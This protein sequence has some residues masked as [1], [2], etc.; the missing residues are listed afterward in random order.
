MAVG[1]ERKAGEAAMPPGLESFA[2]RFSA[3]FLEAIAFTLRAE[4]G[5]S[6]HPADAGGRTNFGI[7]RNFHPQAWADG[8]VDLA[9]ALAIYHA[10]YW[11]PARGDEL[12]PVLA[13][14]LFDSAVLCGVRRPVQWLQTAVNQVWA[15]AWLL[16]EPGTAG[17]GVS[18]TKLAVDG[19]LGPRTLQ[20]LGTLAVLRSEAPLYLAHCVTWQRQLHHAKQVGHKPDQAVFILGWSHRCADLAQRLW[21]IN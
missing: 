17:Q 18:H 11:R 4:G 19:C 12:P 1:D 21:L 3:A 13:L 5:L 10:E 9:E 7:A 20:A 8:R 6:D 15:G 16:A 2:G 14:A